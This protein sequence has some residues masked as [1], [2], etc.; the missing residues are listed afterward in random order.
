MNIKSSPM[1]L[2]ILIIG[3]LSLSDLH[4]AFSEL[5]SF[6]PSVCSFHSLCFII[7]GY[8]KYMF[9]PGFLF[10]FKVKVLVTQSHPILCNPLYCSLP[11]SSVHGIFQARILEWVAISSSRA[12]SLPRDWTWVSFIAGRFFTI[13]ATREAQFLFKSAALKHDWK[14]LV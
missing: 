2:K 10:L 14:L 3:F 12:S 4:I 13:W 6:L 5:F 1:L 7:E 11:G 8:F 9:F